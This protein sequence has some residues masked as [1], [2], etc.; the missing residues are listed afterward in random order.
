MGLQC[1]CISS[2]EKTVAAKISEQ[3]GAP[4]KAECEAVGFS[5][6]KEIGLLHLTNFRVTSEKRGWTRGKSIP[7]QASY[8]P[9]CGQ[10]AV[11]PREKGD[12]A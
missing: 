12:A 1:E 11:T 6:G 5:M 3:I 9:F 7:V 4:A 8:C 10:A 2:I